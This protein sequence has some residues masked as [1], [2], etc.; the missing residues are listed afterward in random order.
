[1][2]RDQD[3][4]VRDAEGQ[5]RLQPPPH[6]LPCIPPQEQGAEGRLLCV[7]D[8]EASSESGH[9]M[10][11]LKFFTNN[12]AEIEN[13]IENFSTIFKC[14]A[15]TKDVETIFKFGSECLMKEDVIAGKAVTCQGDDHPV[16]R[17]SYCQLVK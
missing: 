15:N 10:P 5:D 4:G 1:V 14:L 6:A 2:H 11:M 8:L 3:R 12:K 9:I 7:G 16:N 13:N 17:S